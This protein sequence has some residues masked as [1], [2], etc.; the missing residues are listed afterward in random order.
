MRKMPSM[1]KRFWLHTR[2]CCGLLPALLVVVGLMVLS[3]GLGGLALHRLLAL[4]PLLAGFLSLAAFVV[5]D[6]EEEEDETAKTIVAMPAW[7]SEELQ[8]EK[9]RIESERATRKAAEEE[10]K[11]EAEEEEPEPEAAPAADDLAFVAVDDAPEEVSEPEPEESPEIA[12]TMAFN[13]AEAAAF[14]EMTMKS[15]EGSEVLAD[16]SPAAEP[17]AQEESPAPAQTMAFNPAEAEAF[18]AQSQEAS[19]PPPAE[20]DMGMAATVMFDAREAGF[21]K[22]VM[23]KPAPAPVVPTEEAVEEEVEDETGAYTAEDV[24]RL[25]DMI[26]KGG[27]AAPEEDAMAGTMAYMPAMSQEMLESSEAPTPM[28]EEGGARTMAYMPAVDGGDSTMAYSPEDKQR[29]LE[30]M[31][32][33]QSPSEA[34]EAVGSTQAY[35][36]EQSAA[37]RDAFQLLEQARSGAPADSNLQDQARELL[38]NAHEADPDVLRQ[39]AQELVSRTGE[40]QMSAPTLSDDRSSP[41]LTDGLGAENKGGMSTLSL[42]VVLLLLLALAG[43]ATAF[44][45]HFLGAIDLPLDLPQLDLFKG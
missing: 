16:L 9:A 12:R 7:M 1:I 20:E 27:E 5:D 23:E 14:R 24:A 31:Q 10:E 6:D 39:Q 3:G 17:P 32:Q 30:A 44:I 22:M 41:S 29:I 18:K 8:K 28:D 33:G 25:K 35:S 40:R 38:E 19:E 26:G 2:A 36:P 34:L 4:L 43:G 11:P 13:P 45:L 37:L 42:I 15:Q 21:D